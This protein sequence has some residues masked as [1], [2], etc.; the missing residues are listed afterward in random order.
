MRNCKRNKRKFERKRIEQ[1]A[2]EARSI[3]SRIE[4]NV[5]VSN[6]SVG[7]RRRRRK[8]QHDDMEDVGEPVRKDVVIM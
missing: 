1:K 3:G 2:R 6:G 8:G 7:G 4:F 5:P